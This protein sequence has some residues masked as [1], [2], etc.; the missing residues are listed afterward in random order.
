[1]H[2]IISLFWHIALAARLR[3][4]WLSRTL[5]WLAAARWRD[6]HGESRTFCGAWLCGRKLLGRGRRA[7]I[8]TTWRCSYATRWRRVGDNDIWA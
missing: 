7:W 8:A 5:G 6:A 1:M 2:R 3:A 4:L